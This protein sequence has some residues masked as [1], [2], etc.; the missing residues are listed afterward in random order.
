MVI[1]RYISEILGWHVSRSA[2]S[3]T[4]ESALEQAF[5]NR[6]DTLCRGSVLFLPKSDNGLVVTSRIY[7]RLVKSYGLQQEFITPHCP[8]QNGSVN[9]VIRTITEQCVHR[10][11]F[12]TPQHTRRVISEWIGFYNRQHPHQVL[13]MLSQ[14]QAFEMFKLEVWPEQIAL[15]YY[16]WSL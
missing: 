13:T 14:N 3:S 11:Q 10:Q 9:K 8:E 16:T 15:G 5:I 6:Y 4:A 12:E 2:K 1:D 7:T